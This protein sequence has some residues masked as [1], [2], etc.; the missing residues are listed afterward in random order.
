MPISRGR[1]PSFPSESVRKHQAGLPQGA[2]TQGAADRLRPYWRIWP[3]TPG[4]FLVHVLASST[5]DHLPLYP[6]SQI[7]AR[8]CIE[9]DRSMLAN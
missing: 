4:C 1:K 9:P 5:G 3:K 8:Q 7:F 6:A 2:P